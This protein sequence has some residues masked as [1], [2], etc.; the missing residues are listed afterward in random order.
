MPTK[1]I[2]VV[3]LIGA[4]ELKEKIISAALVVKEPLESSKIKSYR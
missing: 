4:I 3:E 2:R 1:D